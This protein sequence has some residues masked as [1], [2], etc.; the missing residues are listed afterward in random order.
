M[1]NF[2]RKSLKSSF[3]TNQSPKRKT[4]SLIYDKN[5]S[6]NTSQAASTKALSIYQKSKHKNKNLSNSVNTTFFANN[7]V[8]F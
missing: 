2:L 6:K 5:H 3:S 7:E 4:F 1:N 8:K